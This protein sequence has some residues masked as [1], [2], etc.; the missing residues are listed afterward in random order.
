MSRVYA[1]NCQALSGYACILSQVM[2]SS[3]YE[4]VLSE[5]PEMMSEV[6]DMA[7]LPGVVSALK[8]GQ[9]AQ[10]QSVVFPPFTRGDTTEY[11]KK[12]LREWECKGVLVFEYIQ[13]YF[14]KWIYGGEP[15][16]CNNL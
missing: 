1:A 13:G 3:L 10:L 12:E 8:G 4:V 11:L 14:G 7:L 5:G 16:F 9:F 2:S 15:I 6:I